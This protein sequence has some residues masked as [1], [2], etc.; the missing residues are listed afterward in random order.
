[1]SVQA[2]KRHLEKKYSAEGTAWNS[3]LG[4]D[5]AAEMVELDA[6][7]LRKHLP[8]TRFYRTSLKTSFLSYREVEMVVAAT[9]TD[10]K[11]TTREGLSPIF[12]PVSKEF[13][14]QFR[15]IPARTTEERRQ[16][17]PNDFLGEGG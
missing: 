11:I 1:L 5:P 8:G 15:G 16:L 7:V 14:D 4:F 17:A 2:V 12:T 9:V 10:G 3:R 13:L 6:P